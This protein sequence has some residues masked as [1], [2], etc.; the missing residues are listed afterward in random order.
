MMREFPDVK[1][2]KEFAVLMFDRTEHNQD[3]IKELFERI[4][5]LE[6]KI[7]SLEMCNC[8][9]RLKKVE[10]RILTMEVQKSSANKTLGNTGLVVVQVITIA[11]ALYSI[12]VK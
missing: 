9:E 1:N 11:L 5:P 10:D 6:R 7:A 12:F 3:D 4:E 8:A 2:W